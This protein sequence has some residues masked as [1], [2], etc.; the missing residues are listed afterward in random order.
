M[1]RTFFA[2]LCGALVMHQAA[3]QTP[4]QTFSDESTQAS[5]PTVYMISNAHLDTQWNWDVVTTIGEY[6]PNTMKRNFTLFE[7]FPE[8]IFNFEGAVKYA[9]MKEYYPEDYARV[10]AYVQAGRWHVCGS[11]WDAT[12]PNMPSP[13]SFIRNILYGQQFYQREFGV[14]S[15]DIFLPD[16]FGFGQTLPTV[17]AHCGLLGFSTQKLQWRQNPFYGDRKNPFPIGLWQGI[18]GSRIMMCD[19]AHNYSKKYKFTDLSN[20]KEL[21]AMVKDSGLG[22]A[23]RY[24]GTGDIGGSPTMESVRTVVSSA[25]SGKGPLQLVIT[26]A[27]QIYRDFAP[28]EAHPELP[29]WN[30]ELLMDVHATGC[31]TSQAAMKLYNR[32]NEQM[33]DAAQR[34]SSAAL[35]LNSPEGA[36]A[37]WQYP[38]QTID[39]AWKRVIWHQFHDDLTGTSI[40]RA[41]EFSWN[42]EL[43]SLNQFETSITAAA[44]AVSDKMNTAA[45]KGTPVVLYNALGADVADVVTIDVPDAGKAYA[46]YDDKGAKVASQM[47]QGGKMSFV[48]KV[49]SVGYAVYDLRVAGKA[50]VS[51][52]TADSGAVVLQKAADVTRVENS[53]YAVTLDKNGDF[54][55]IVDKRCGRELVSADKPFRLA[56]FTKNPSYVWPAWEILRSTMEAEPEAIPASS[57][58][59]TSDGPMGKTV[60]VVRELG[61]TRIEQEILL[62]EGA[63]AER[64]DVRCRVHWE[65]TDALLKAEFPMA[66]SNPEAVYDLGIGAKARGNNTDTKYEVY[67][68]Q[69]ADLTDRDGS[70]GVA[71]MNDCKYGWDKPSDNNL[72]LTL[73]HTPSTTTNYAYQDHQ[74]H[75]DH[76]FTYSIMGHSGDYRQGKVVEAAQ[77]MNQ[78]V[79]AWYAGRHKGSLGRS[80]S[81]ASSDNEA[82]AIRCIKPAED[83]NGFVVRVYETKGQG[84]QKASIR[85]GDG[86]VSA[87]KLDGCENVLGDAKVSGGA[88]ECEVGSYGIATYRVVPV[89]AGASGASGASGAG[90]SAFASASAC[91]DMPLE[92]DF[93]RRT[94]SYNGFTGD[95]SLDVLGHSLAAELLPD[96]LAFAGTYFVLG[97]PKKENA[98]R[99]DG[100]TL[101][102]PSNKGGVLYLLCN[103]NTVDMAV[104][105]TVA[106]RECPIKVPYFG[107]FV[108]QWGHVD[109]TEA[110][111]KGVPVAYVGTHTHAMSGSKDR[112]YEYGYLFCQSVKVPAGCSEVTLPKNAGV[113][114]YAATLV[115]GRSELTPAMNL[116]GVHTP[117]TQFSDAGDYRNLLSEA[118]VVE[119]SG[120]QNASESVAM[121]LDDNPDTK[122]CDARSK[123]DK[124]VVFDLGKP[125]ILTDWLV[126]HAGRESEKCITVDFALEG[127]ND[128]SEQ[129]QVIDAVKD[130]TDNTTFRKLPGDTPAYRYLRFLVSR[131][132][133]NG[134]TARIYEFGVH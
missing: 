124:Y 57:V 84:V 5:K 123:G 36:P 113:H 127:R 114:V 25:K 24:Y 33:G 103:S 72:R 100:Q 3:A 43:I 32:R 37:T 44:Q 130:N 38:Y 67:A 76:E 28:F 134:N 99:C 96:T 125:T 22:I 132:A 58:K 86:I 34:A 4:S 97:D 73:L 16:C 108:G 111:F 56:L 50:A 7:T 92:L 20:N 71:V 23:Y 121:M 70:Y 107:G 128:P 104:N 98:L 42:D 15:V 78:G 47:L 117:L 91:G 115:Q 116:S 95:V 69:W 26:P 112:I 60:T 46:I 94:A 49:P 8:Y 68:Q 90:A 79:K 14:Q 77:L 51:G 52:K 119:F 13:E 61:K 35:W 31:Y 65:Q 45:C 131:G 64:I 9:W 39:E 126:L 17:A 110:F 18:D 12:D 122:W 59:V 53:V 55:S 19:D 54:C 66:V 102:L 80:W 41:Y 120:E 29:V 75:G 30:D 2:I 11:T 74:D 105:V 62:H 21:K 88:L 81:F 82:V 101:T 6:I 63:L 133:R 89:A 10:K 118:T 27:D 85:L 93:N 109:H 106:G 40:P 87:Q 129:W 83:S 1:K 48:A